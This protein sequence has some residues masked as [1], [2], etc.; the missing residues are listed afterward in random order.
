MAK[1]N[2]ILEKEGDS[3]KALETIMTGEKM[4]DTMIETLLSPVEV[5]KITHARRKRSQGVGYYD[6]E[7]QWLAK[8][9]DIPSHELESLRKI[10]EKQ[11]EYREPY[12]RYGESPVRKHP[13]VRPQLK[14][15]V[16]NLPRCVG[17]MAEGVH[18]L[19]FTW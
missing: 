6:P 16:A 8:E 9:L 15:F 14:I 18:P 7:F 10:A 12:N 5:E 4:L 1:V 13:K 19:F 11:E 17:G 2:D 3:E